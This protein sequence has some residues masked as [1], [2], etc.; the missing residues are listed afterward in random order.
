MYSDTEYVKQSPNS[1]FF[2]SKDLLKTYPPF[3]NFF[4]M[5]K[6]TITRCEKQKP[7]FHAFLKVSVCRIKSMNR[8]WGL[9]CSTECSRWKNVKFW[10]L[11]EMPTCLGE[12]EIGRI[13]TSIPQAPHKTLPEKVWVPPLL[14]SFQGDLIICIC[15][16]RQFFPSPCLFLSVEITGAAALTGPLPVFV[17]LVFL[18]QL[19]TFLGS[20]EA[21]GR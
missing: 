10:K 8:T 4:E 13:W 6:E 15:C 9:L 7:R 5:S 11:E 1:C 20:C 19:L 16:W 12:T 21:P 14:N 3:V 17:R 18:K 2:Q